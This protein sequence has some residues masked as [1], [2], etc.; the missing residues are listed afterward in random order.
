MP[1]DRSPQVRLVGTARRP[2]RCRRPMIAA[3]V[4]FQLRRTSLPQLLHQE[5]QIAIAD[6]GVHYPPHRVAFRRPQMQHA[7][8]VFAGNRI[9]RFEQIEYDCAVFQHSRMPRSTQK[10]FQKLSQ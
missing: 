1:L 5:P 7:L 6:I 8:V 2:P 4:N 9:F 3:A 10:I